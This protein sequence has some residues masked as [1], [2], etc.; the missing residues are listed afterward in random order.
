MKALRFHNFGPP[1]VL[2]IEDISKPQPSEGE[3]LVEVKAAAMN[4]SD[5][6]NVAG[7]FSATM[8]P[9]TPGRDFAGIVV[10]GK[11][12]GAE[13]WGSGPG[14]G[15]R[16]DGAH[17]QY[18]T[19]PAEAVSRKPAN[20]TMEQAAVIGVPYTTA[21]TA[22][23]YAAQLQ[24]GETILVVG[25][26][27]AVGEAATQI[28]KWKGARVIGADLGPEA[29]SGADVAI[30]TSTTGLQEQVMEHTAGKGV[31]VVLDTV[32]GAM[33]EPSLRS[34]RYG[35]R[36]VSITSTGD[37]RVSFDLVDFYHNGSHL[38]GVDSTRFTPTDVGEIAAALLPGFESNALKPPVIEAVPFTEAIRAYE[39][40]SSG[41]TKAKQVL[42]FLER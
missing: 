9:R 24:A 15:I 37:R 33:F 35:G 14:F 38:I 25:A 13:V 21:W 36:Q 39:R 41:Q 12:K 1:S 5:V 6:K 34:L 28:A 18:V 4:P 19:V 8:L 22:L 23:L 40:V 16:R 26:R 27:G 42:T 32:G 29:I 20:L 3:V 30:D 10:E 11:L 31:D 17:A 2:A 7:N